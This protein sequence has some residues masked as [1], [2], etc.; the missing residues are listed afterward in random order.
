V[1]I[2][3]CHFPRN[4]PRAGRVLLMTKKRVECC[5]IPRKPKNKA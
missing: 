2:L 5:G 1:A 4:L 3:Q